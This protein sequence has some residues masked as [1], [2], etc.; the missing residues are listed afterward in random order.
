MFFNANK[1]VYYFLANCSVFVL[2]LQ[3]AFELAGKAL[4]LY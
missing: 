2:L 4:L 1:I 3:F